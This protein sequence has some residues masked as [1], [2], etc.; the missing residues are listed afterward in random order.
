M[1][2]RWAVF[3]DRDG[4]ILKL[5][6]YLRDPRRARLHAGAARALGKLRAA[7][8]RLV[9]VTNQAGVAR[10]FMTRADVRR[11]N[12]RLRQLLA[13]EGVRL[14]R[15]EVCGHHPEYSGPCACRKPAPGMLR[16]AAR[17]LHVDLGASWMIGD[18]ESDLQAGR[19]AGTRVA[20]VLTGYGRGTAETTAGRAAE[21]VGAR[22]ESVVSRILAARHA[23]GQAPTG[24]PA[25]VPPGLRRRP[26]ASR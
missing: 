9:V 2:K 25:P 4:T 3:L 5:V 22:L 18:S 26:A 19:A 11:V 23:A 15:I 21:I 6:P 16:S 12:A 24:R 17:R 13:E 10:G 8:A 1:R 7:G 14:D 20:L